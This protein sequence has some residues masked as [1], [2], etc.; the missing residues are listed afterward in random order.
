MNGR[1]LFS[2]SD[3]PSPTQPRTSNFPQNDWQLMMNELVTI[4]SDQAQYARTALV[5]VMAVF[6]IILRTIDKLYLRLSHIEMA[7]GLL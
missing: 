6:A 4:R 5:V 2:N 7:L 3:P 1:T